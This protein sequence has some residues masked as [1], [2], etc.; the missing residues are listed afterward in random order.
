MPKN[1]LSTYPQ[2]KAFVSVT[3]AAKILN[4]HPD[5]L[6]NWEKNGWLIPERTAGGA[7]RYSLSKLKQLIQEINPENGVLVKRGL[8]SISKAAK[9]LKV[10][11]DTLRNW[12]KNGLVAP[13]RTK[14]GS[15]RYSKAEIRR[16]SGD[17]FLNQLA[18]VI[19]ETPN[20]L[21]TSFSSEFKDGAVGSLASAD[22]LSVSQNEQTRLDDFSQNE[23]SISSKQSSNLSESVSESVSELPAVPDQKVRK[24]AEKLRNTSLLLAIL[25]LFLAL[26][27]YFSPGQ[28][29]VK[30][31]I[32]AETKD[33]KS[34]VYALASNL[35]S[36]Q[37]S[38]FKI[39]TATK[40]AVLGEATT[41]SPQAEKLVLPAELVY[42]IQGYFGEVSFE[43][44]SDIKIDELKISNTSTLASVKGRGGC[45]SCLGNS[46]IDDSLNIS[47]SG[48]I[49]ALA[50]KSDT[51]PNDRLS[52]NYAHVTGLGVIN[53]G[54]WQAQAVAENFGGTAQTTYSK[55]DLLYSSDTNTLSKLNIGQNGQFLVVSSLGTPEWTNN[56]N[57]GSLYIDT[58]N[59]KVG[60]GTITPSSK[61]DV[62]ADLPFGFASQIAN[63]GDS[64]S[65]MGLLIQSGSNTGLGSNTLIQFRD[66]DGTD[67]G[68][69]SF[70]GGITSYATISD[71]RL[72][73]DIKLS[74]K[75][76]GEVLKI[77][78]RDF[79]FKDDQSQVKQT[80]FIAQEL[81]QV[82]PEAVIKGVTNEDYWSVDYSKLT[83]LLVAAVQD[84]QKQINE[85]TKKID[86]LN[87]DKFGLSEKFSD[88]V[89]LSENLVTNFSESLGTIKY[90]ET[91]KT[92]E[93]ASAKNSENIQ[94]YLGQVA[95][96]LEDVKKEIGN[97]KTEIAK[98]DSRLIAEETKSLSLEKILESLSEKETVEDPKSSS[99]QNLTPLDTIL[100]SDSASLNISNNISTFSVSEIFKSFG[101]SFLGNTTIAGDLVIDGTLALSSNSINAI[102]IDCLNNNETIK[103]CNNSSNGVLFLQNSP[104]A[105]LVNIF[106]GKVLIDKDGTIK[107]DTI[108]VANFKVLK[109]QISGI[110]IIK[111]GEKEVAILNPKVERTSRILITPTSK[112]DAVL[113]VT[114][115]IKGEKF[116][117]SSS[118]I[119]EEEI[120][121]DWFLIQEIE[122]NQ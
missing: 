90:D 20:S 87:L 17:L 38:L 115:K 49:S 62:I 99:T 77:Q 7:R 64:S 57:G 84:Q 63:F 97:Q 98:L 91:L 73:T 67:V 78:V 48:S 42:T 9:I 10:S 16:L 74:E 69:I 3:K 111:P 33:L 5:T 18:P 72:K 31:L 105:S 6:R 102:G 95:S 21:S 35:E 28:A 83:P 81:N 60:I 25:I 80:G 101:E 82:F 71:E 1:N 11:A 14:G 92:G 53:S 104:L 96:K 59:D 50:I 76:L 22:E 86:F 61:L 2:T 30:G 114:D 70:S 75:G 65:R 122:A 107:S 19:S 106:D 23:W 103:Q 119:A 118:K 120:Q 68:K 56:I 109:D 88:K 108:I 47:S 112:V 39:E 41:A 89:V 44:G 43:T 117:V 110:G 58:V 32:T 37:T 26:G 13:E 93:L 55:G 121:F 29:D 100:A 52:G 24:W 85:I 36:V 15:R 34:E 4:V 12:E 8:L 45:D 40:A 27:Y 113:A 66:G 94:N 79:S 54:T 116:I 46:D 51:L